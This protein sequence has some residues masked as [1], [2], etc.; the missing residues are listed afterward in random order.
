MH[1][2]FLY[3]PGERLSESELSAARI[4][5]HVVEVG[6]AY[7]PADLVAGPDVRAS[8][9]SMLVQPGTA[10]CTQTAAWIHGA[11]DAPPV[12]HHVKRC[13][14]R[15]IRPITSARLVFHDTV[16]PDVDIELIGGVPVS[17]P[18][19]TM[20]DLA[21][22]LHRDPRVLMW[23]DRLAA[24]LPGTP[25]AAIAA[26]RDLHRVPGSRAGLAALERLVLRRR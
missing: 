17:T 19:R 13:I 5:G 14:D 16:L 6:D 11:G 10:A 22:T 26:L 12:V 9:V 2:A 3:V 4:D 24:A 18:A 8:S 1:P 15:R 25:K 21:T 7:I 23:M 20:L